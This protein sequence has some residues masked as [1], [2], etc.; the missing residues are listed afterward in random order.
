M[1]CLLG[2]DTATIGAM[3]IQ[4]AP[5]WSLQPDDLTRFYLLQ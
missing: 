3:S 1:L 5:K 2:L 4:S